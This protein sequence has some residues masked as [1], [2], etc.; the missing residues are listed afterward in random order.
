[1]TETKG[2]AIMNHVFHGYEPFKGEMQTRTRGSPLPTTVGTLS[3]TDSI[4]RRTEAFC[5]LGPATKVYEGMDCR[6]EFPPGRYRRQ[7]LA[8]HVTNTRSE[9]R[10]MS[11]PRLTPPKPMSLEQCLEFISDD[12]LVEIT[13]KNIRMRKKVLEA[14]MRRARYGG[15]LLLIGISTLFRF[16][17]QGLALYTN[18]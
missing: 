8:K 10:R 4:T 18:K 1:M 14:G 5:L 9:Q 3:H 12:E 2:T 6:R 11:A 13:P 16:L 17:Q 15:E 7:R